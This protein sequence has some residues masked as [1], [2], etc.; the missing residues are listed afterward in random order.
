MNRVVI[1]G[2]GAVSPLGVGREA[3][4]EGL[5]AGRSGIGPITHFDASEFPVRIGGEIRD[6]TRM[7]LPC[8]TGVF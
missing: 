6:A 2:I 3:L 5:A 4:W 1:T 7:A 8:G